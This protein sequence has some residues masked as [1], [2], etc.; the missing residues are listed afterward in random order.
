MHAS[1]LWIHSLTL[2]EINRNDTKYGDY[3]QNGY[4]FAS[5]NSGIHIKELE[6]HLA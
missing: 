6:P 2:E 5:V 3:L 1:E 4:I